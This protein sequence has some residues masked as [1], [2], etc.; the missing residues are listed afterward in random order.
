MA[1]RANDFA[2]LGTPAKLGVF[3]TRVRRGEVVGS[4]AMRFCFELDG[5]LVT[6][7]VTLDDWASCRP[8]AGNVEIAR[9][10]H[11]AGHTVIVW[12]SRCM[13]PAG[14]A[15]G[16]C[17]RALAQVGAITFAQLAEF[18]VPYDEIIFG[19]PDADVYV[20][21]RAVNSLG[22][23]VSQSLGWLPESAQSLRRNS[24][25]VG[26]VAPRHFNSVRRVGSELVEKTGPRSVLRGEI[27]WYQQVPAALADLFPRVVSITEHPALE[28]SSV[29]MTRVEGVTFSHLLV[30]AC[31]TPG[32][33]ASL[34]A[35]LKRLHFCGCGVVQEEDGKTSRSPPRVD[36]HDATATT[37]SSSKPK[38]TSSSPE[39]AAASDEPRAETERAVDDALLCSNYHAKVAARFAK[40][41][42]FYKSFDDAR[43]DT[44][45]VAD[46]VLAQLQEY[47]QAKRF[48]RTAFIHGDPVFSNV[49]LTNDSDKIK[50]LDMRGALGETLTTAGDLLYDLS[51]VYQSLC[52]YDFIILDVPRTPAI[53]TTLAKLRALFFT[54]L[55][56]T[57]PAV[58][59]RDV[60]LLT[61]AHF[62]CIVPLHDNATH[63]KAFLRASIALLEEENL[64]NKHGDTKDNSPP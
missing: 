59:L 52:G 54:W 42:A 50:L 26:G 63:Q 44:A 47:E 38:T 17:S 24:D 14:R 64:L 56:K 57:H 53:D 45:R 1:V 13:G 33:L 34:L 18:G 49:L 8:I 29:V 19:K 32:R 41:A 2:N 55:A 46:V 7:P 12:T 30:N 62:F 37:W 43:L 10:L 27:Y 25:L 20:D 58:L 22:E 23:N 39:S 4:R 40:H 11:A 51:K 36:G 6:H 35:A 15:R 3:L 21:S 61:A 16:S 5:T 9:D 48:K 28:L 60:K 31:V